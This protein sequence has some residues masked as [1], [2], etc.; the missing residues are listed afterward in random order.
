[1]TER[2]L[3]FGARGFLG[4]AVVATARGAGL[5]VVGVG[6]GGDVDIT[7]DV[8]NPGA[9]ERALSDAEPSAVVNCAVR[10]EFGDASLA[11]L[12][13]V[14]ALAPGVMAAW[15]RRASAHLVHASTTLVHGARAELIEPSTPFKP[16]TV[17]G[18][19]K[20]I[21]EELVDGA[22]CDAAVIRLCGIYGAGGPGHLSLNRVIDAARAGSPPT[23]TG[24][25]TARRNYI[26]V[27]DAALV[28]VDAVRRRLV[29]VHLAAGPETLTI[30]SMMQIVCDVLLPGTTPIHVEGS[31]AAD[32]IVVHAPGLPAGRPM[33][34]ALRS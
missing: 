11:E 16:D 9:L 20:L 3:V 5:V 28:L 17:Y 10:V 6:R 21:A 18:H 15:C 29:G 13:P 22:G 30:A 26:H 27:D 32:Q 2:V 14:N 33:A 1:M 23:V 19:S 34:E 31:E 8:G 7:C 24:R 4:R 25:G 12:F